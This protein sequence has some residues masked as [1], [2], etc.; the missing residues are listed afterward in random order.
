[1]F[2]LDEP[3]V[4]GWDIGGA[5]LKLA[6]RSHN[7]VNVLQWPCPL[8]RGLHE[9]RACLDNAFE[10]TRFDRFTHYVTMTGELVDIFKTREQG[11]QKILATF[12]AKLPPKD[13]LKIFASSGLL[14]LDEAINNFAAVASANWLVSG[15]LLSRLCEN[16]LFVD[17]GSTTTDLL[18]VKNGKLANT[19]N[20]DAE[21]L[22]SGELIYTGVVR[23]CVNTVSHHLEY[24]GEAVP[25]VAE[26]FAT[27]ADVYR[28][29]EQLP[30]HADSGDTM[31]GQ[32]K[33]FSASVRR[34]A[35]MIGEDYKPSDKSAWIRAASYIAEQQKMR[36]TQHIKKQLAQL[37][38]QQIIVAAGVGRFLIKQIADENSIT[39][40]EITDELARN[41]IQCSEHAADCA[42]ALALTLV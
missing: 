5:H 25:M 20:N 40:S 26:N 35:R 15:E 14:D 33:D 12:A 37:D 42:P 34:L 38:R 6:I 39:Y 1:M 16:A 7:A 9:L 24:N 41:D 2:K 29:L 8:W 18:L 13:S 10:Q 28:I 32:A 4:A 3:N 27:T 23:S 30:T 17:M 22:R 11:V 19:G 31:D 36:L 21:R